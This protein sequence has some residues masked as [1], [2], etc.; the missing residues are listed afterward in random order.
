MHPLI[1][2]IFSIVGNV[3]N[4]ACRIYAA[5]PTDICVG[6]DCCVLSSFGMI[7]YMLS[8]ILRKSLYDLCQS[9]PGIDVIHIKYALVQ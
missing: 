4:I 8:V 2:F 3:T 7:I 6:N 1:L 9:V 5:S